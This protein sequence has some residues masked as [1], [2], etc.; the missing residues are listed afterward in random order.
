[1]K[2]KAIVSA[3]AFLAVAALSLAAD[4]NLGSWKLNEEKSHFAAGATK[5]RLVSYHAVGDMVMVTVDGVDKDGKATHNEWTGKFDG[6]DYAVKG[7][8]TSD[9]RSY[10]KVNANTLSL[11]VKK[12][13]KTTV[14]GTIMVSADGKTRTVTTSGMDSMGMKMDNM[15]VYDKQ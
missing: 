2:T 3:A 5:N 11:T 8:A 7:D 4:P 9:M 6:K 13:G 10:T 12:D 1:M 15:A 14:T